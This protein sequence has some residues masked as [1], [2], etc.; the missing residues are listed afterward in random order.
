MWKV[1]GYL[2]PAKM[3]AY[4]Y[5][6]CERKPRLKKVDVSMVYLPHQQ[7]YIV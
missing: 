2:V 6:A 3:Y 7:L 4:I 1:S 5:A